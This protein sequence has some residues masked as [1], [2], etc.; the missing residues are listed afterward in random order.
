MTKKP[1]IHP[2]GYRSVTGSLAVADV[3]A[4]IAFL[5]AAF[6]ASVLGKDVEE[7]PSF[8]AVK[9]GN[10]QVF[11]TA[12]NAEIGHLPAVSGPGAACQHVYVEDVDA[13]VARAVE[14]GAVVLS[15]P[16][17]TFWG[18][19]TAV[20]QDPFY[21]RW[22]VATRIEALSLETI[23]ERRAAFLVSDVAEVMTGAVSGVL[24]NAS[25]Q[26]EAPHGSVPQG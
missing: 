5:E 20:L 14:A 2:K 24:A 18:E 25:P 26:S 17:E 9:I 19:R 10:A 11:L 16:T 22:S 12:G 3:P 15:E 7:A 1:A 21:Q 8:A 6:D 4:A 23:A 13:T